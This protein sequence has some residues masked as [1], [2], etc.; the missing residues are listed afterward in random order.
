M[1]RERHG[2]G[3]MSGMGQDMKSGVEGLG[4]SRH[5]KQTSHTSPAARASGE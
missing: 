5:P 4:E 3:V 1:L 2:R